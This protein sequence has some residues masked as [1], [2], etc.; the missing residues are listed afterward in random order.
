VNYSIIP[1]IFAQNTKNVESGLESNVKFKAGVDAK[2]TVSTSLNLDLSLNPDFSQVEV[3]QQ[4]VNLDR[5]EL[6][7]PERRQFFLENSDLF[8]SLGSD[9]NRPFFSRRIGLNSPVLA[10]ARLSG[11]VSKRTRI[12]LMNMQT[13]TEGNVAAG[14]YTVGVVQQ[15]IFARSNISFFMVNKQI[16]DEDFSN[17]PRYNRVFGIDANLASA[18]SKWTGKVF[19][20]QSLHENID[21]DAFTLSGNVAYD[22]PKFKLSLSQNYI[23]DDYA[24]E[25][26]FVR[27]KGIYNTKP[28]AQYKFF[29][30]SGIVA[31]HGPGI[32]FD[33]FLD[34]EFEFR[35]RI[36]KLF[37]QITFK[38]RSSFLIQLEDNFIK[39]IDSFDPTNSGGVQ[40][41]EN[42]KHNWQRI[43]ASYQ[44]NSRDLFNYALGLGYGGFFNGTRFTFLNEVSYRIQPYAKFSILSSYNKVDLPD[45]YNSA[46]FV[47]FGPKIDLTFTDKIFLTTFTQYNNQIDN[48]N[49]NIRF[50]WRFAPGSDLFIVYTQNSY[51]EDF[52]SK[53]R[54]LVGKFTYWFN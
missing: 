5:F 4:Q 53:N 8:A 44:S 52:E 1:Y 25:V 41:M 26:G 47:L 17:I 50:Q 16:T 15:Q 42:S 20:H 38:D 12:G 34:R 7:F 28:T 45:P 32:S 22:T 24:A 3:D 10:G 14:N 39:L 51:P 46:N 30:K 31:N 48:V 27:R 18:D 21:S 33:F 43:A 2:I 19:Y 40:L 23:G 49:V 36:S 37:Y 35:D 29:P 13:G 9:G 6:F 54:G 11:K